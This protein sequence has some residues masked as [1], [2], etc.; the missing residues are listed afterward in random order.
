MNMKKLRNGLIIFASLIIIVQLI[1][2]NYD[3]LSWKANDGNYI[4][5]FSM[6][7]L[8]VSMIFSNRYDKKTNY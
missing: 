4:G 8:I 7:C 2:L 1:T 5:I 3:N 6:I